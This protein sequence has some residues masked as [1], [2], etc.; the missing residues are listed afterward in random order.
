ML[1]IWKFRI[2]SAQASSLCLSSSVF[3]VESWLI[4]DL[5]VCRQPTVWPIT[6][7]WRSTTACRSTVSLTSSLWATA[8]TSESPRW[9]TTPIC[10]PLSPSRTSLTVWAG[11]SWPPTARVRTHTSVGVAGWLPFSPPARLCRCLLGNV[12]MLL[13]MGHDDGVGQFNGFRLP[14]F[15][16]ALGKSRDLLLWK[17]WRQMEQKQPQW[18]QHSACLAPPLP[19]LSLFAAAAE[20]SAPPSSSH[21]NT[22]PGRVRVSKAYVWNGLFF[23]IF[24]TLRKKSVTVDKCQRDEFSNYLRWSNS[25]SHFLSNLSKRK[26]AIAVKK[27][28]LYCIFSKN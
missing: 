24:F 23:L 3:W 15:L 11:R 9:R 16:V 14:R 8:P 5:C 4:R 13:A 1:L 28:S 7:L 12:T 19:S 21:R 27:V 20:G 22:S 18:H 17:S 2:V 26:I 10:T 6:E 25:S